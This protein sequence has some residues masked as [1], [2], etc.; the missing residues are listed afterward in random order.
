MEMDKNIRKNP[1]LGLEAYKEGEVLYGRDDDIRDLSQCVLNDID[2][3]LYG[4]SGIGKSSILNAGILPA[5]RRQGYLPVMIRLSH[6]GLFSYLRQIQDAIENTMAPI[7]LDENGKQVEL[8]QEESSIRADKLS[9]R[10]SQV[11]P[12]KGDREE[13][14]YEYFHR[15][16]FYDENGERQKLLLIFDQ[17]EEIFSLQSNEK[18]KKQFFEELAYLLNDVVPAYLQ[19]DAEPLVA[20]QEEISLGDGKD[21]EELFESLDLDSYNDM[22]EYVTDNDIHFVFT[23]REDF[24]SEFEY[25]S[26]SIPSLRQNRYGLR[27]INEEQASQIILQPRPGL[28]A[29][30]VA[31]LIIQKVTGRED[32]LID[33]TPELEVD[34]AVLSLYLNRLYEAKDGDIITRELVE[35]RGGEI[36]SDFYNDAISG[37]SETTIEYL[38][39]RLLNGQNRRDNITVYD[40]NNEG[41]ISEEE[42]D[43][44]C[45]KK[46][47]LRQFNYAGDLRIEFVHDILCPVVKEHKS[48]R[49]LLKQQEEER[50]RQEEEKQRIILAEERKRRELEHKAEIEKEQML[51]IALKRQKRRNRYI[52]A[53][54]IALL[55]MLSLVYA[56]YWMY[57]IDIESYYAQFERI[58]GWPKGVGTPLSEEERAHTPLY[59]RLYH[60]GHLG[61][62]TDV[63]VMSSN[64]VLPQSPRIS[65]PE[66]N[67]DDVTL[68]DQKAMAYYDLLSQVSSIHFVGDEDGK[69]DKEILKDKDGSIL[70]VVNY[71]HLPNGKDAWLQYVTATGHPLVFS[72][73][74]A[75]RIKLSWYRNDTLLNDVNNGRVETSMYFDSRDNCV[76]ITKNISGYRMWYSGSDIIYKLALDEYGRANQ[77]TQND[78]NMSITRYNGDTVDVRYARAFMVDTVNIIPAVGVDNYEKSVFVRVNPNKDIVRLYEKGSK[79]NRIEKELLKDNRGNIIEEKL[80]YVNNENTQDNFKD[81]I[82]I[83][84]YS[85]DGL[86]T[87]I[88]KLNGDGTPYVTIVDDIYKKCWEYDSEGNVIKEEF[89]NG[90]KEKVYFRDISESI[91]GEFIIKTEMTYDKVRNI[92]LSRIDSV[93]SDSTMISFYDRFENR[94]CVYKYVDN[95]DTIECHKVVVKRIGNK[96]ITYYYTI[97]INGCIIPRPKELIDYGRAKSF[98]C[99]EQEFDL[100]GNVLY[101]RLYDVDGSIIKSMMYYYLNGIQIARAVMGIEGY[102]HPVRC[103]A[104]EEDSYTY[105]KLYYKIDDNTGAFR[106]IA[107]VDEW[108][109]PSIF[110][111]PV[112]LK[113]TMIKA[114]H[115]LGTHVEGNSISIR[116]FYAKETMSEAKNI[117]NIYVPYLHILDKKS[118][119]YISGLRDGDRI[120][121]LGKWKLGMPKNQLDEEWDDLQYA[122]DSIIVYRPHTETYVKIEKSVFRG[123]D[124]K[125]K[126]KYY[127]HALT[128]EENKRL[129]KYIVSLREG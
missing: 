100:D 41:K 105:Y 101:Y 86:L 96:K 7:R 66:I 111:D 17:F 91:V 77:N 88:E 119:L 9:K 70:Y 117:S 55:S 22:P 99:K 118:L 19:Q 16:V 40:A 25:Y 44:L 110:Y 125:T 127:R 94:P 126:E 46:K 24:L 59:Y 30:D 83:Y 8:T 81:R 64:R 113:Y 109:E 62:D 26:A 115:E 50:K 72:E 49:L 90:E 61:F 1:W 43:I 5:A 92:Y 48:E 14:L 102:G 116:Y 122:P 80:V 57:E 82:T 93:F 42:L 76:P 114:V 18:I 97:D 54:S 39:K 98:Y 84:S 123:F 124:G 37:I 2:T 128:H 106:Q 45:N 10:I 71:Y 65:V 20:V 63:E 79:V 56:Y 60:K 23:I 108:N 31:Q 12:Q 104:W 13:S 87:K 47:I 73:K 3:L 11:I 103:S 27:P 112:S 95:T 107:A 89:W 74:G 51:A 85:D 33:G 36:I 34:S 29:I 21:V 28:I 4:K 78:Y 69:I 6:K 35:R 67:E 120:I 52:I 15:H 68:N 58:N 121:Q 53:I 38:E 129:A 32:F 75:N